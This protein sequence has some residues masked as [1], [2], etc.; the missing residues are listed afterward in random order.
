MKQL[1]VVVVIG[2]SLAIAIL[3]T[4]LGCTAASRD[5][6]FAV[7]QSMSIADQKCEVEIGANHDSEYNVGDPP[8]GSNEV[9]IVR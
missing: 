9:L 7:R 6:G 4:L 5:T 8:V 3:F 1:I 2:C